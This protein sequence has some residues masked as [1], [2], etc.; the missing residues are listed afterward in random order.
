M[1][2]THEDYDQLSV[3]TLKGEFVGEEDAERLRAAAQERL[4]HAI[5]DVVLD[6]EHVEFVDSLGLESMLWLQDT[7]AEKLGQV[8]LANVHGNV[9]EALRVTRLAGRLELHADVDAAINSLR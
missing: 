4:D 2:L 5:R 3:F 1:K 8:R 9:T 6:L 7:C